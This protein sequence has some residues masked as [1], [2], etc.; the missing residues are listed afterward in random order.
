MKF[1]KPKFRLGH[2]EYYLFLLSIKNIFWIKLSKSRF[3][4]ILKKT[5]LMTSFTCLRFPGSSW[6]CLWSCG[7][8]SVVK[9]YT[10]A[11][12]LVLRHRN[13]IIVIT[14]P[15]KIRKRYHQCCRFSRSIAEV[16]PKIIYFHYQ[17]IYLWDQNIQ[18]I[19]YLILKKKSLDIIEDS[20]LFSADTLADYPYIYLFSSWEEKCAGSEYHRVSQWYPTKIQIL[21]D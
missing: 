18:K 13:L 20:D 1:L 6:S 4:L 3:Y 11:R 7:C 21:F 8:G 16:T 9:R 19:Y 2:P 15:L 14:S 12:C 5:S 17:K 10:H